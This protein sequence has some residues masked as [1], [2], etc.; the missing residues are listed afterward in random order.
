[1]HG[2]KKINICSVLLKVHCVRILKIIHVS[3]FTPPLC[4]LLECAIGCLQPVLPSW[5]GKGSD[6]SYFL[7][8]QI[9]CVPDHQ[10]SIQSQSLECLGLPLYIYSIVLFPYLS[11]ITSYLQDKGLALWGRFPRT[12]FDRHEPLLVLLCPQSLQSSPTKRHLG[13]KKGN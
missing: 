11:W 5:N 1:M 4:M 10:K 2:S 3:H 13:H 9:S 7:R 8:I 6:I 12:I